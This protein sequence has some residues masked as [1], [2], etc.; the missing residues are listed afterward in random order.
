MCVGGV[1]RGAI[2][3]QGNPAPKLCRFLCAS[4]FT[5]PPPPPHYP[6]A[7]YVGRL[8]VHRYTQSSSDLFRN[9][10]RS[11]TK[12]LESPHRAA[13]VFSLS[14]PE[15][16]CRFSQFGLSYMECFFTQVYFNSISQA[17]PRLIC[18]SAII[19]CCYCSRSRVGNSRR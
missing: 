11:Q 5:C 2:W 13:C 9:D 17:V 1:L 4:F 12:G 18:R 7:W 16:R 14:G 6:R 8:E 3:V 15:R 10:C 19:N